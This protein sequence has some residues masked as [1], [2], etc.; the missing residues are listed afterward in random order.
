VAEARGG[1]WGASPAPTSVDPG[2]EPVSTSVAPGGY[3]QAQQPQT[4]GE[5]YGPTYDMVVSEKDSSTH[6]PQDPHFLGQLMPVAHS[7]SEEV[8]SFFDATSITG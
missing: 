4:R 7:R 6:D 3:E 1:T 8:R 2:V 5:P